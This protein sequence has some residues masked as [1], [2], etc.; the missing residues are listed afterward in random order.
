MKGNDPD[1]PLPL[2]AILNKKIAAQSEL[3]T[4]ESLDLKFSNGNQRVY[5]RLRGGMRGAVM[6]VPLTADNELV[7][8]REYAVGSE[9][10]ELGFP[11]GIIDPGEEPLTA[12]NRELKEEIGFG[13]QQLQW[14]S[15]LSLAPGY[16]NAKMH[17]ILARDLYPEKLEGDE[18]EPLPVVYWP[19]DNWRA[20]L[21]RDDFSEARC[22]SSLFLLRD[23]LS[24]GGDKC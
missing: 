8:I 20:L 10:Y 13:A 2:P 23:F 4:V 21:E 11:K 24:A 1:E 9:S 6:I 12:A 14:L 15:C 19:L 3:F 16:M 17:I 5:E 22:V 7:L 18:P